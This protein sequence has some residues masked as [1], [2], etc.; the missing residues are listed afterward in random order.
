MIGEN[1]ISLVL[2]M[3]NLP[4]ILSTSVAVPLLRLKTT[5][6]RPVA[7]KGSFT[8]SLSDRGNVS[9]SSSDS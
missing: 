8:M 2:H 4:V 9:P 3:S 5:V 1:D 6:K 7:V